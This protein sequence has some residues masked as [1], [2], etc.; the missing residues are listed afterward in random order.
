MGFHHHH[1]KY[2][3]LST[4]PWDV[5]NAEEASQA[6]NI[7]LNCNSVYKHPL[8][9]FLSSLHIDIFGV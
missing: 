7:F 5:K 2:V 8:K 1:E 3:E 9:H 4:Q 6:V